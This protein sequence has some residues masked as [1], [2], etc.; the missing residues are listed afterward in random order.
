[1][2]GKKALLIGA[3]GLTGGVLLQQLLQDKRVAIVS[4]FVRR[5]TGITHPKLAEHIV[6]FDRIADWQHLLTGDVLFSALGTTLKQAKS[7]EAQYKVD[8]TYQYEC[9]AA[10]AKNGVNTYVLVSSAG[11]NAH[12]RFF[13]MKMKGALE[14]KVAALPFVSVSVMRPGILDGGRKGRALERLTIAAI[15]LLNRAG[16]FKGWQPTPVA[17]LAAAMLLAGIEPAQGIRILDRRQIA[18]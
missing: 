4:I 10:A 17:S 1:M 9:A 12:S 15:K 5:T 7:K 16:I 13:Y 2:P 18:G 11:A 3:T 14:Q 6:D 8:V